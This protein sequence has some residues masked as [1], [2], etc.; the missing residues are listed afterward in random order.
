VDQELARLSP[1]A[2]GDAVAR[3]ATL[4]IASRIA[5]ASSDAARA[6]T[7]ATDAVAAAQHLAR[8]PEKSAD[9]GEALLLLAQAQQALGRHAEAVTSATRAASSLAAG[10]SEGH[11]LTRQ[12]L[13]IIGR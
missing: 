3:A 10:L 7:R 12:A 9:L 6:Q 8:D 5:L 11:P 13:A 1:D 4:R 2:P